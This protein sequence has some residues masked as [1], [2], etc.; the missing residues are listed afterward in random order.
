MTVLNAR[1][2]NVPATATWPR[3]GSARLASAGRR[4]SI[5]EP[6]TSRPP[7]KVTSA[8]ERVVLAIAPAYEPATGT[9][10]GSRTT[11]TD[12][13]VGRCRA[14]SLQVS[15]SSRLANTDPELVP[16]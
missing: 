10:A 15:P 11:S 9:T 13:T 12:R 14:T 4:T 5:V 7:E 6:T 8:V 3:D 16:K 2:P 1:P